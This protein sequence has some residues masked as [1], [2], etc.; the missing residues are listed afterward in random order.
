MHSSVVGTIITGGLG[1][2]LGGV[3]TALIQVLSKKSESRAKA[4]DI[5]ADAAGG[6]ADRLNHM[7]EDLTKDNK[8]L[9]QSVLV[10]IGVVDAA[11]LDLPPGSPWA[12]KLRHA[13]E[14]AKLSL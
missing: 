3:M 13:S 4:A 7:N 11:V 6:L 9:R 10:L 14:A 5:V 2:T 1:A 12:E 8:V